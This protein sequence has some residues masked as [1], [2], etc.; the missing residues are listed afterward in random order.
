VPGACAGLA[1]RT[2][3]AVFRNKATQQL[4]LFIIYSNAFVCA[5]LADARVGIKPLTA[6]LGVI[7]VWSL[8]TH[9]LDLLVFY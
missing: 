8:I 9:D 2:D 4:A 3:L 6:P 7:I 1:A 5:K